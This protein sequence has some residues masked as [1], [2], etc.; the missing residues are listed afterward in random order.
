M[1][2]EDHTITTVVKTNYVTLNIHVLCVL[3]TRLSGFV[4]CNK[5]NC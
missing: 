2:L 3:S 4:M 1:C 5:S